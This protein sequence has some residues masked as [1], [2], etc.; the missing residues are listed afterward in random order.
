MKNLYSGDY[1]VIM[2]G[3]YYKADTVD[4]TVIA[5]QTA[6]ANGFLESDPSKAPEVYWHSPLDNEID[7]DTGSDIVIKFSKA[8][9]IQSVEE[10]LSIRAP[11]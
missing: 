8:M 7:V 2:E 9:N 10:A 6:F 5:G 1:Q 3:G 11:G 4:V